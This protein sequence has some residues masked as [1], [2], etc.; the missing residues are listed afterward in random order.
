LLVPILRLIFV[1]AG[2]VVTS[3]GIQILTFSESP[4]GNLPSNLFVVFA[5]L[6]VGAGVG[7]VLGGVIG[8]RLVGVVTK[9]EIFLRQ[10]PTPD[11]IFGTFG[12]VIGMFLANLIFPLLREIGQVGV[13]IAA[14]VFFLAGSLGFEL[15]RRRK[16]TLSEVFGGLSLD[17]AKE[18]NFS[19]GK[20]LDTSVIIDGRIV[21]IYRAGFI[22]GQIKIP[23]FILKELQDIA[24]SRDDLKR[25]RG[26]R[27]LNMLARLQKEHP[28]DV[29]FL[30]EDFGQEKKVDQKLLKLAEKTKDAIVTV[31]YNLQK[32]AEVQ[33][34]KIL[35]VNELANTLKPPV[36]PGEKIKIKIA[37]AGKEP[38]QGVGYLDDGTM[39][40]VEDGKSLLGE[41]VEVLVTSVLQT[42]S[43]KMIF[44]KALVK[45]R[46]SL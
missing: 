23:Q 37:K 24:D 6:L 9:V 44:T 2:V 21:D 34:H 36:H 31:D 41:N 10:F 16:Q 22:E 14:L 8:R 43:G 28:D 15:F 20:I 19:T 3:F 38:R 4:I 11:L 46:G 33:G 26:R 18:R 39:V 5:L 42:S 30:E 29:K 25:N 32:I 7:Y 13:F 1:L 40:V 45:E 12:L 27:G 35:N 17:N